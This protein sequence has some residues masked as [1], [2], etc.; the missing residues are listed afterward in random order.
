VELWQGWPLRPNTGVSEFSQAQFLARDAG[1]KLSA[2]L[3]MLG[4]IEKDVLVRP[5]RKMGNIR[6]E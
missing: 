3:R 1:W 2:T 6:V 4:N 5:T